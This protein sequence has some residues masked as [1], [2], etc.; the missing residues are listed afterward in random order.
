MRT[1]SP[2][3]MVVQEGGLARAVAADD[4]HA[5]VPGH[6]VGEVA[7]DGVVPEGLAHVVQLDRLAPQAAGEGCH[8]EGAVG[9]RA[10][11]GF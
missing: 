10:G 4:A 7:E 3:S 8:L 11:L 1:V 2:Q 5:V 9:L 6:A